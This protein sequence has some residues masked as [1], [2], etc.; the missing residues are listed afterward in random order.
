MNKRTKTI[1]LLAVFTLSGCKSMGVTKEDFGKFVGAIGGAVIGSKIG[2]GNGKIIATVLGASLGSYIG[3]RIGAS[4]DKK[5]QEALH[6]KSLAV[7]NS[8]Q[9]QNLTSEWKSDHSQAKATINAKPISRQNA[10]IGIVK[11]KQ[12]EKVPYV[13]LIGKPYETL[14]STNVRAGTSTKT[15]IVG[16]MAKGSSFTAVGVT[17][18]NWLLVARNGITLGYVYAPLAIE[19]QNKARSEEAPELRQKAFDLDAIS[20]VE[21]SINGIDL[22]GFDL[23]SMD[24]VEETIVAETE[25]RDLEINIENKNQQKKESFSACK[26]ADGSWELS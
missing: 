3:G 4:L 5:D 18:N 23:D 9:D 15:S 12:V 20:D 14:V 24:L 1:C 8:S 26:A 22:D 25:C 6:R 16:G 2:K 7:L 13:K 19:Q 11:L 17:P 21:S 10:N